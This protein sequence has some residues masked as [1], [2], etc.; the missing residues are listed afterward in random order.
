M[1]TKGVDC[2]H[3][4]AA[5]VEA[6][7]LLR[8]VLLLAA[9][10]RADEAH[11]EAHHGSVLARGQVVHADLHVPSRQPADLELVGL[12]VQLRHGAVVAHLRYTIYHHYITSALCIHIYI[13]IYI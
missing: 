6:D 13:Y 2:R 12:P 9:V 7:G 3:R 1:H 8:H 10:A 5:P 11:R 4:G